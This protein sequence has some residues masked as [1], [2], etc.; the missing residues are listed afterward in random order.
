M[1]ARERKS[2]TA[3]DTKDTKEKNS[4]TAKHAKSAKNSIIRTRKDAEELRQSRYW[5]GPWHANFRNCR[6]KRGAGYD[7]Q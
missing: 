7:R 3:K 6:C 4:L 2:F 5:F 1:A